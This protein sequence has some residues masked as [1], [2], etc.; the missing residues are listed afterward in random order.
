MVAQYTP[1]GNRCWNNSQ[2]AY[3]DPEMIYLSPMEQ[4]SKDALFYANRKT[5]IDFNYLNVQV[6]TAGIPSL[7]I[8]WQPF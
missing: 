4:G 5:F 3:G 6:Q 1:G 8:G 7:K 2:F